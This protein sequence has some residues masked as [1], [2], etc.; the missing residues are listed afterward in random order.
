MAVTMELYELKT[1]CADMAALGVAT[2]QKGQ[3]PA[4]DLISQRE[5]YRQFQQMRVMRWVEQ[6]L[7]SPKRNGSAP[8]SKRYYSYAELMAINNAEKLNSIINR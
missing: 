2:Y 3:A 8:N 6:G 5:A 4:D 7:I 1:L